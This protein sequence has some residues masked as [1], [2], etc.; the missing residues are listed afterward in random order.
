M[1]TT[2]NDLAMQRFR[3]SRQRIVLIRKAWLA[4]ENR[5]DQNDL[6]GV[7][8]RVEEDV[9]VQAGEQTTEDAVVE[10]LEKG[11]ADG[12]LDILSSPEVFSRTCNKKLA[13]LEVLCLFVSQVPC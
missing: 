4:D 6:P 7:V 1:V 12:L 10:A 2:E 3:R 9:R 13:S 5:R 8:E 11:D